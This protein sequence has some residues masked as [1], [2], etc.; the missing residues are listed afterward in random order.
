MSAAAD[1][2]GVMPEG[3]GMIWDDLAPPWRCC[4]EEAWTA[5]R[6]G[7]LPIGAAITDASGRIIARGRNRIFEPA[8]PDGLLAG[9]RLAHAEMNALLAL[10]HAGIDRRAGILYTTT[11]PCPL[12]IG[13][14]RIYGLRD[15]RYAS[16]DAAAGSI[17][18]LAANA[19][20]RRGAVAVT[21]PPSAAL[22]AV[23][24]AMHV[25]R[26]LERWGGDGTWVQGA[27]ERDSPA[28]VALGQ[29][30]YDSGELRAWAGDGLPVESVVGRLAERLK[31]RP[32][33]QE[34]ALPRASALIVEHGAVAV[35]ERRRAGRLYYVF[36]GGGV[37]PG[38]TLAAAAIREAGEELGLRVEIRGHVAD[39]WYEGRL[40]RYFRAEVVGGVFGT[41]QGREI[42]G[43][44]PADRGTYAPIWAPLADLPGLPVY[45]RA[46]ADLLARL[47]AEG[48]PTVPGVFHDPG[49]PGRQ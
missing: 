28:G 40:Q 48:W 15:V 25:E 30:L 42:V 3:D 18:L 2:V 14:A 5:Y 39:V 11:E 16:R 32:A 31:A 35:I 49:D 46:V 27:W 37:E 33:R 4:L 10:D 29:A 36:P 6:A 47:P 44:G 23:I 17:D 20:M 8:A 12:C 26:N 7:S 34:G 38:E 45:P 9:H 21:H 22:E 43:L 41:G 19:F 24:I 1:M 13:A